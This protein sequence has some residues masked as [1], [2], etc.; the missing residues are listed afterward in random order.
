M[1][2]RHKTS[3]QIRFKDIDALGHVNNANHATY[4]ESAR[5]S[6]FDEVIGTDIDWEKSG[7]IL[8][9]IEIDYKQPIL[10]H[11]KLLVYT[12]CT[13]IGS[14]SME[15][16]HRLVKEAHGAETE[17]AS[18]K[19]VVVTFNYAEKKAIE[20]PAEWVTKLK[21]YDGFSI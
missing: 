21:A 9:R 3:I 6:Y 8:A 4:I 1:N 15:L 12:A 19:S 2:F 10:L 7:L 20:I 16:S 18:G 13:R 14:K 5:V 11:D 17:M